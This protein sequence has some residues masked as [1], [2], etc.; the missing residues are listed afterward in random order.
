MT[1]HPRDMQQDLI[2][3]HGDCEKLMPFLHL[4]IQSGA[5]AVLKAMNRKHDADFYLNIIADLRKSRPD[6][7]F[8]SDFI[9][10]FPGETDKD[11]EETL[12]L[13]RQVGY[14]QCYSFKYSPRP[15]TP[16]ALM[17][18]NIAEEIKSERLQLLQELL[19][20][21]QLEFNQTVIGK[22]MPVLFDRTGKHE[23]QLLG[24][25]EY[26]QSVH[27]SGDYRHFGNMAQSFNHRRHKQNGLTGE[28][29]LQIQ[30]STKRQHEPIN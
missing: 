21:Q 7:A 11:F 12:Q 28:L 24:K 15:G 3:A 2:K 8:S 23:G 6:L 27:L 1:S 18:D 25:T 29:S 10:G 19:F 9:V 17:E 22:I 16:G 30:H 4:P 26:M 13:V 14:S 20:A 5:N